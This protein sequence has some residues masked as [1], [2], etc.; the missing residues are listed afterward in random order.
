MVRHTCP[1]LKYPSVDRRHRYALRT[2]V[3]I[4]KRP[5]NA[6]ARHHAV[7]AQVPGRPSSRLTTGERSPSREIPLYRVDAHP[8]LSVNAHTLRGGFSPRKLTPKGRALRRRWTPRGRSVSLRGALRRRPRTRKQTNIRR[9]HREIQVGDLAGRARHRIPQRMGRCIGTVN[10]ASRLAGITASDRR[11][12]LI[13]SVGPR[14][15]QHGG[16]RPGDGNQDLGRRDPRDRKRHGAIDA[17]SR[18]KI[19]G[20][21]PDRATE[22]GEKHQGGDEGTHGRG[23]G[24]VAGV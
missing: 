3:E 10:L 17:P 6:G 23:R 24:L 14:A 2:R 21:R 9:G 8:N 20:P 1:G 5:R 11:A 16:I 7:S 15:A 12:G 19:V 4:L 13:V 18:S 22:H